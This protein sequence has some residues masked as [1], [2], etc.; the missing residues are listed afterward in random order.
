MRAAAL[1]Q[2]FRRKITIASDCSGMGSDVM[3]MERVLPSGWECLFAS[4]QSK[5][6]RKVLSRH[7][8]KGSG[9]GKL[10][11]NM[12]SKKRKAFSC[13]DLDIYTTGPPC[14]PYS[15]EGVGRGASDP[16]CLLTAAA[17]HIESLRPKIFVIENVAGLLRKRHKAWAQ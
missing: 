9:Q 11:R 15:S 3:A 13:Q 7:M 5:F 4:D 12:I 14:Q 2:D 17:A 6:C 16:R 10:F 8:K 1:P